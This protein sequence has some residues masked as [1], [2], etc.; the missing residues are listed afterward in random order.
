MMRCTGLKDLLDHVARRVH[1]AWSLMAEIQRKESEYPRIQVWI[2]LLQDK[3]GQ[4]HQKLYKVLGTIKNFILLYITLLFTLSS[5][6]G[7]NQ[8]WTSV[9]DDGPKL[10]R[11][12]VNVSYLLDKGSFHCYTCR[13]GNDFFS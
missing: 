10:N 5:S 11:H 6:S 1:G 7:I 9:V 12:W 8:C 4:Y 3:Q 13:A 2:S